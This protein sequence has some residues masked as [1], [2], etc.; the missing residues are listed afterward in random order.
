MNLN[1]SSL[2]ELGLDLMQ[3][4]EFL[5]ALGVF[6]ETVHRQPSDHRSR[7]LA[8]RCYVEIGERERAVMALHACAEGLLARDF[9]LSA[10][11]ACKLALELNPHERMVLETLKRVHARAVRTAPGRAAIPPPAPPEPLGDG[12]VLENLMTLSGSALAERALEVLLTPDGTVTVDLQ[13]RPPLPLF[14]DLSPATFVD[15]VVGLTLR[16]AGA[17]TVIAKEG[18][19]GETL[20]V[21]VAGQAEVSRSVQGEVKRLGLLPGG[22]MFGEVSLLTGTLPSATVTCTVESEL[23]E[24]RRDLLGTLSQTHPELPPTLAQFAQQ[25]MA[26]NLLVSSPLFQPL[27][28]EDRRALLQNFQFRGLAAGERV[29]VEGEHSQGLFLVLAGELVVQKDDPAGGQVT[30]GVLHEGDVAGEI[31]LITGL[32]ATA[33]V[34]ATRK[35]ATAFLPRSDF[36]QLMRNF[37]SAREYLEGLSSRRLKEIGDALRPMEILDAEE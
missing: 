29:L 10:T 8:A 23:F 19:G 25:R 12:V 27:P 28:M 24:I 33:T 13:A 1:T 2:R 18:E 16:S 7:V 21:I 37:P 9:L 22:S 30:L 34:A 32:R 36:H 4:R 14:A 5:K 15:L 31:S 35:T 6:A 3:E 26:K 20:Y 11:A 17:G